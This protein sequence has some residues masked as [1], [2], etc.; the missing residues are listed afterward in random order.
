M[1]FYFYFFLFFY[2]PL[3]S[4]ARRHRRRAALVGFDHS[5]EVRGITGFPRC[6]P[7]GGCGSHTIGM[8]V[9]VF[10]AG[11][12]SSSCDF[13]GVSFFFSVS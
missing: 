7:W 1:F 3:D 12:K 6:R 9:L 5:G 2:F 11:W 10:I 4:R 8:A 13:I